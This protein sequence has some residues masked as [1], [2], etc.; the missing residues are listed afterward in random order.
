LLNALLLKLAQNRLAMLS[1]HVNLSPNVS[2]AES[3]MEALAY[4]EASTVAL[5]VL[6]YRIAGWL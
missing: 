3:S 4:L 2:C 6:D 5:L 1:V